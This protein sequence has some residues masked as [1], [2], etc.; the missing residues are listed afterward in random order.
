MQEIG[1]EADA[2]GEMQRVIICYKKADK[3][4]LEQILGTDITKIL[5][6]INDL[7]D[8]DADADADAD[9]D[10]GEEQGEDE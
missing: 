4:K 3:Q 5:Y 6:N 9:T 2:D 1:E 8:T 7:I 10:A